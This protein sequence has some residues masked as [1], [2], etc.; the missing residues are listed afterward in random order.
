MTF[1]VFDFA[2]INIIYCFSNGTL[3]ASLDVMKF[4]N[5]KLNSILLTN[6]FTIYVSS[7][8]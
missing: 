7:T 4:I 8:T 2:F 1:E 3:C 6:A 5:K